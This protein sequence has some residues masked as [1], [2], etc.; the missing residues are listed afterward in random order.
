M[1]A[2]KE[3]IESKNPCFLQHKS[4]CSFHLYRLRDKSPSGNDGKQMSCK[5]APSFTALIRKL[6]N[7]KIV[8]QKLYN[9]DKN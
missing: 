9:V 5:Q 6:V 7:C 3:K 1:C 8:N 4:G 2:L